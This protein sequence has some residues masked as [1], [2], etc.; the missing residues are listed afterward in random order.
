MPFFGFFFWD[1][2]MILLVPALIL[3][4]WAQSRVRG[5]YREWSQVPSR[6]GLSGRAPRAFRALHPPALWRGRRECPPGAK[7]A[8][9]A[10]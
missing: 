5:A 1:P 2:T 8:I 7:R 4:V 6:R 9:P 3:A 10:G